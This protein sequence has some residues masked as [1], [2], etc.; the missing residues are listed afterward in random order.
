MFHFLTKNKEQG[1]QLDRRGGKAEEVEEVKD[2]DV[3]SM[4]YA[5]AKLADHVLNNVLTKADAG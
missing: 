4:K 2:K 5:R 1:Q 3:F